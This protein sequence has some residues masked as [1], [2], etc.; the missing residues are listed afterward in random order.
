MDKDNCKTRWETFKFWVLVRLILEV[1]LCFFLTR[2]TRPICSHRWESLYPLQP[3]IF[4]NTGSPLR[5][6]THFVRPPYATSTPNWTLG[7]ECIMVNWFT[8]IRRSQ[9]DFT[10]SVYRITDINKFDDLP[11]SGNYLPLWVIWFVG[12]AIRSTDIGKCLMNM[13]IWHP[14]SK[15]RP[16]LS[17]R[18]V[19][20]RH[21]I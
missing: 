8:D 5:C 6:H 17:Q 14:M 19:C 18:C 21:S 7:N 12:V 10:M 15:C 13:S 4:H 3:L 1:W 9:I 11:T 20:R 2:K 16:K